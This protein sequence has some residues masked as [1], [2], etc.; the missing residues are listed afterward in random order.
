MPQDT[1]AADVEQFLHTELVDLGVEE[2]AIRPDAKFDQ[3]DIDSLDVADL[4]TSVK[5][6]YG[7]DIP[8]R[9]LIGMTLRELVERVVAESTAA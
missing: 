5:K 4:M 8:R 7:V 2:E 9:D 1:V 3:L 6:S